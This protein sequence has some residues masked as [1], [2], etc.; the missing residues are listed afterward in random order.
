MDWEAEGLL[1]DCTSD[2]A[3]AARRALLDRLH[4]EGVSVEDLRHAVGTSG[5]RCCPSSGS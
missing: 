5:S 1:E 2:E 3:R 4:E